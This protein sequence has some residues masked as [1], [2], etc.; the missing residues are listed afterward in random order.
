MPGHSDKQK[1]YASLR[2]PKISRLR[3][4]CRKLS[5]LE[6]CHDM[7][8]VVTLLWGAWGMR[9]MGWLHSVDSI[10][11]QVSIAKEPYK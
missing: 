9:G 4:H 11:V 5:C 6:E 3:I 2:E 7:R 1:G 8:H 10:K